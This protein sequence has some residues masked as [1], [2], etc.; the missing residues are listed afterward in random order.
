MSDCLFGSPTLLQFQRSWLVIAVVKWNQ[1][2]LGGS[3]SPSGLICHK[4]NTWI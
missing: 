3:T 2:N 1:Q 4:T